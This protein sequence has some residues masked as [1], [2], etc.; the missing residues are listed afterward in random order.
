MPFISSTYLIVVAKTPNTMLNKSS[1]SR[2][3]CP[4]QTISKI[5]REEMIPKLIL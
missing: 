5:S 2:N 4:S 1:E 3:L